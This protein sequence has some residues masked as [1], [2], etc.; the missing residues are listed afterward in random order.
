MTQERINFE[1]AKWETASDGMPKNP[2]ADKNCKTC[3]GHGVCDAGFNTGCILINCPD[4]HNTV[5]KAA[6]TGR[7]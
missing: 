5:K 6:N 4:C 7:K 2:L 1:A 3:K